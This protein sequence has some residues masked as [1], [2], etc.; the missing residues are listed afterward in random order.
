MPPEW[1]EINGA[2]LTE[3]LKKRRGDMLRAAGEFYETLAEEVNVHGTD[4]DERAR[5]QRFD[6]GSPDAHRATR[7]QGD[8]LCGNIIHN[9][10]SG[11]GIRR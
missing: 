11:D 7:D 6:D 8:P 5:I 4:R 3:R 2:A 9:L 10:I 1:Y